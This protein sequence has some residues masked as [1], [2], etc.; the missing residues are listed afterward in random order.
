M[1]WAV[2]KT[3]AEPARTREVNP[4][5]HFSETLQYIGCCFSVGGPSEPARTREVGCSL[6]QNPVDELAF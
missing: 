2:V 3:S 1:S 6:F 4:V 5:N